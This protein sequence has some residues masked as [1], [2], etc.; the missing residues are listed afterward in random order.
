L[1]ISRNGYAATERPAMALNGPAK[2]ARSCPLS[3]ADRTS[4][5]PPEHFR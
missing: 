5:E 1:S 3:A 2:L 4:F